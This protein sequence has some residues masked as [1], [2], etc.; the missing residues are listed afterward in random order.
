MSGI[1][2][3]SYIPSLSVAERVHAALIFM[4]D[5]G[6]NRVS[7]VQV[8]NAAGVSRA[9]LYANHRDLVSEIMAFGGATRPS[10]ERALA[11]VPK[12]PR[13]S[14]HVE[15]LDAKYRALLLVCIEQQAEIAWLRAQLL[16]SKSAGGSKQR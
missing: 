7:V 10:R 3:Q 15:S 4:K 12:S 6:R 2:K 16:S 8:C 9:N 11:A 5:Q 13:N 14:T 1:T